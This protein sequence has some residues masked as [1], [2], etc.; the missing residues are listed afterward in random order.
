[1][2]T[3]KNLLISALAEFKASYEKDIKRYYGWFGE[4]D[5]TL[6]Q[7]LASYHNKV[8]THIDKLL[9]EISNTPNCEG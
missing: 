1:V 3:D 6:Y 4:K 7:D 2:E 9:D 8:I 5:Q